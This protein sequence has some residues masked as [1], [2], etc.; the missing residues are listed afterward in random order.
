MA[1]KIL[2]IDSIDELKMI[3]NHVDDKEPVII[4]VEVK[5]DGKED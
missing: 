3:L 2:E 1:N 4:S 5:S